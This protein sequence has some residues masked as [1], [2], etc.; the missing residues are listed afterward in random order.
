MPTDAALLAEVPFFQ[1][2]DDHEREEL[3]KQLDVV[4]MPA[5]KLVFNY[6]DPGESLYV[7]RRGEVE[8][9]FKDDTGTRIVLET[10]KPG[11]VFGELSLLDGGARTAT[12]VAI[13]ECELIVLDRGDLTML[14]R[15]QPEA[16]LHLLAAMGKMTRKADELIR[17]RVSRN[18]NE[19]IAEN[20]TVVEKVA[21][22]IAWFSGSMPFLAV[23]VLWF[24]AWILVNT[25]GLAR[26]DPYPF[27]L[28]TMIV[29]L[30]AIFLSIFVLVSQN[31][32]AAK[33]RVRS[34]IEYEINVKAELE[35]AH[36]HEKTDQIRED[37]LD[38]FARLERL[39]GGGRPSGR[40]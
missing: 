13:E 2:L 37:V 9:F 7:I 39:L 27:G 25:T 12:A 16:A 34:D 22:W 21:D 3:S 5:G 17:T 1:L 33:D 14:F 40:A 26:F 28:L 10:G 35:V 15:K 36:L 8:I 6:R 23:N 20:L 32:Q 30:E 11:D 18:A 31:R 29:S 4:T 38:R 24:G 19:E